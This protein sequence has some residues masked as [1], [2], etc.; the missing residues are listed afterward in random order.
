MRNAILGSGL[1]HLIALVALFYVRTAASLVIP[2]PETVQVALLDPSALLQATPPKVEAPAPEPILSEVKPAE[3]TGVKLQPEPAKKKKKEKPREEV[4]P[5][6][7]SPALPSA[8]VGSAGL[9]GDVAVDAR[10]FEFTYY[11]VL[12][13]NRIAANWAPPAGLATGGRRVRAVIGFRIGRG[14][15][16]SAVRMDEVSGMEFF[17]R[18][19]MRAVVLS[20]PLPPLPLG[21]PASE[22]GVHFGF[23]WEA[24]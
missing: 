13:R 22:L 2:G 6:P 14:G 1:V 7:E 12:V 11:L 23:E 3:D 9:K 16:L 8:A 20:D 19:A 24:P 17:D 21:Y 10:D 18:S 4:A 5:T 15:G